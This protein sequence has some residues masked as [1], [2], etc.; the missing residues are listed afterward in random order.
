MQKS[1]ARYFAPTFFSP[2]YFPSLVGSGTGGGGSTPSSY[3]DKDA[4]EAIV[5]ALE[6]TGEFAQVFFGT[7]MDQR[8]GGADLT[9]V[10]VVAPDGWSED[11]E[12]D[13]AVFVRRV[14]FVVTVAV[15]D[16]DSVFR[17]DQADRLSCVVQN[18]VDL[19]DLDGGCIAA[20]T[21][22]RSG[23]TVITADYPEEQ[24]EIRG[25]FAYFISTPNGRGTIN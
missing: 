17:F 4:F 1:P 20:L 8:L 9:P 12:T 19:N 22:T 2:F 16:S 23:R 14:G 15:R 3:R 24:V 13:P 10:A 21:K 25:E 7:T 18:A 5:Q 11:D 6:A